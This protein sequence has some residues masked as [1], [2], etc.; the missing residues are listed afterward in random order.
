M[1][2]PLHGGPRAP[3]KRPDPRRAMTITAI[4][5]VLPASKTEIAERTGR[6]R[7][8][9]YKVVD[10]MASEPRQIHVARWAPHPRGGPS[11]AIYAVGN[12]EDAEDCLPRLTKKQIYSR[13]ISKLK[14]EG[15]Y[16]AAKAKWRSRHWTAKA[17]SKPNT[18]L[19]ILGA[20]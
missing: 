1:P 6:S 4:L 10:A 17:L 14:S 19:S 20:P 2:N 5:A 12:G 11:I 9:I 16:D 13:H 7:E 15:R 3:N 8:V 18:W